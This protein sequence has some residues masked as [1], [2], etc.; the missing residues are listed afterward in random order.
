MLIRNVLVVDHDASELAPLDLVM[1]AG[2]VRY[3]T[4]GGNVFMDKD[5]IDGVKGQTLK[6]WQEAQENT[7]KDAERIQWFQ[8]EIMRLL[9]INLKLKHEKDEQQ[10]AIQELGKRVATFEMVNSRNN[11]YVALYAALSVITAARKVCS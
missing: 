10:E 9:D 3:T 7:H 11:M 1:K 4:V 8:Q 6:E 5:D 2:I